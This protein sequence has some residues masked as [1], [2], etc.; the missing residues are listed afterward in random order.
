MRRNSRSFRVGALAVA[1]AVASGCDGGPAGLDLDAPLTVGQVAGVW[2]VDV[3]ATTACI[4][5]LDAFT[6][7]MEL[8]HS[9]LADYL[10][11]EDEEY[12]AGQWWVDPGDEPFFAQGWVQM[13][14][15]TFRLLLWQGTHV[16]GSVLQGRLYVNGQMRATLQEP[17]PPGDGWAA[18]PIPGYP[19][20]F[21]QG[22]C[23][24]KVEGQRS[25]S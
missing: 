2:T 17:I 20:G 4:P 15:H 23:E 22:N 25:G 12:F 19:G 11:L 8:Q 16:K 14:A 7:R 6:I 10:G 21:A 13:D 24:W 3:P 1:V 9:H 5:A 18:D